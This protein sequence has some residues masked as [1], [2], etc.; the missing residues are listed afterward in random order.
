MA[1]QLFCTKPFTWFEVVAEPRGDVYVC[2]PAWL[3]KPIG[4]LRRQS[5]E[6]V[7]NSKAAQDIRESIYDGSFKYCDR[8]RCPYLQAATEVDSST[9]VGSP[10]MPVGA[11][12]DPD[13][14]GAIEGRL[15]VIPWGP[16]EVC[17]SFDKSCNLSC[18]SC[19]TKTIIEVGEAESILDIRHKIDRDV[20]PRAKYMH[21]TGSGDAFG[22]PFFNEW[23][24]IMNMEDVSPDMHIHIHTNAQLWSSRMWSQIPENVRLHIRSA[25]ISIDAATAETYTV[26]RRGGSFDRLMKNLHFIK[27]LRSSGELDHLLISM[28]VQENNFPEMPAFVRLGERFQIDSVYFSQ[29]VN[30]GTFDDSEYRQRAVHLSDHPRH[31]DLLECLQDPLL[32]EPRVFL[33][34]LS[35]L[36]RQ[37]TCARVESTRA[38]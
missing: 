21:I 32:A 3:K 6:E 31:G 26:N 38:A 20:I 37:G 28:V 22:S 34:N 23:L 27:G 18:P 4:N 30:W 8:S 13:I 33:G 16:K 10:V 25:E 35:D 14:R 5:V 2:C 7:W 17:C 19:R 15:T 11:V 29:L 9:T 24:R 1:D 36:R 12:G